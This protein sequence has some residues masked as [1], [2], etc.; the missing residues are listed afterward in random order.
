MSESPP[1]GRS[2]R[3]QRRRLL[4]SAIAIA[5]A[6]G[7]GYLA[8]YLM[9]PGTIRSAYQE[10]D[11]E[12]ALSRADTF[13]ALYPFAAGN[14]ELTQ[15][16]QECAIYTLAVS[17]IDNSLWGDAY[18]A[19]TVY[20]NLYPDGRF[21]SAVHQHTATALIGMATEKISAKEYKDALENIDLVLRDF[22]DTAAGKDAY[23]LWFDAQ[24]NWGANLR[25]GGDFALAERMFQETL[26]DSKTDHATRSQQE[27]AQTYYAWGLALQADQRFA[28]AHLK[29]EKAI[30]TDPEM[31]AESGLSAQVK[32]S[33]IE[34]FQQWGDYLLEQGEYANAM[35]RYAAAA[36]MIKADDP[37]S[38]KDIIANGYVQWGQALSARQD[39]IGALVLLDFA[40][41]NAA[42]DETKKRIDSARSDV[43]LG[44]SR[45]DGEQAQQAMLDAA[46]I[47]CEHQ[48]PSRLPMLGLDLENIRTRIQGL[49]ED[50]P[51]TLAV[52]TPGSMHYVACVEVDTKVVESVVNRIISAVLGIGPPYKFLPIT[53]ERIQHVW[54]V[55]LRDAA[56]GMETATTVIEG[57]EP[58]PFPVTLFEIQ[59]RARDPRFWGTQPEYSDLVTWLES[60]TQ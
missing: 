10:S 56:T 12:R 25:D 26:Q 34:L 22:T 57:G 18:N 28:E 45:S 24:M 3:L 30:S 59:Q 55:T 54:N 47:I 41:A 1:D 8:G 40:Q 50:L 46:R 37:T 33:E 23:A 6:L 2:A 21:T 43:Y 60:V 38:G 14:D 4:I 7:V 31:E 17:R 9:L 58:P 51:E 19:L 20:S 44:F 42:S 27:L 52:T 32:T 11:C 36:A 5:F 29:L 15:M 39:F 35:A 49:E 48:I 53:Y 13:A 16:V